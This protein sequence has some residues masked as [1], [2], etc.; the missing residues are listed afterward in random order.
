[1]AWTSPPGRKQQHEFPLERARAFSSS[2]GHRRRAQPDARASPGPTGTDGTRVS[3]SP[4]VMAGVMPHTD[5]ALNPVAA[6][7]TV[8]AELATLVSEYLQYHRCTQAYEVREEPR[9]RGRVVAPPSH[10]STSRPDRSSRR[11]ASIAPPS[12]RDRCRALREHRRRRVLTVDSLPRPSAR[13]RSSTSERRRRPPRVGADARKSS[14]RAISSSNWRVPR[15][16]TLVSRRPRPSSL[17]ATSPPESRFAPSS[18]LA[19]PLL[20]DAFFPTPRSPPRIARRWLSSR[21]AIA[22]I[23]FACTTGASPS[24]TARLISTRGRLTFGSRSTLPSTPRFP[25]RLPSASAPPRETTSPARVTRPT[26]RPARTSPP[27]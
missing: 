17:P 8:E 14:P 1:M 12:P 22:R 9:A 26:T 25:P 3:R 6:D 19:F 20:T 13:R 15:P 24:S 5:K 7:Q 11:R 16:D 27:A 10:V 4:G 18:R 21:M 2:D 23:F